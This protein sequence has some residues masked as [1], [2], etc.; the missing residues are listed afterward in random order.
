MP[1]RASV[2]R[3]GF[4]AVVSSDTAA[5]RM[6]RR[7]LLAA[8]AGI[9][10]FGATWLLGARAG[11]FGYFEGAIAF[12]ALT[13]ALFVALVL[14]ALAVVEGENDE[15][16]ETEAALRESEERFRGAFDNA[17]IG[18]ALVSP[19]GRWL[20]VNRSICE[21]LGYA[22]KELLATDFQ[23]VTHPDDLDADL[24][25]VEQTL[26][27]TIRDYR[28][29]KRYLH[30]GGDIVH[31]LLAVSLVR[32]RDGAPLYFVSQ[33]VDITERKRVDAALV[34]AK[35]AAEAATRTKS[36][37]LASMSHE[38]RTP[39]NAVIGFTG[40]LL[41]TELAAEQREFLETV[42]VSGETLLVLI[43]DILDFSKIES[44]KLELERQ[45]VDVRDCVEEALDLVAP[46]AGAKRLDLVA[47]IDGGAPQAVVGDV[48]RLR[49]ILVNLLSNAVKFTHEGEVVVTADARELGGGRHELH[50]AVRDTG[51]GI[52]AERID[53]LFHAFTQVDASVTRQYG[54]TG[55]GLAICRRLAELMGGTVWAESEV[56]RGS[57]F[58]FTI[59]CETAVVPPRPHGA[60]R[61]LDGKR[62]LVVDD[63]DASRSVLAEE[64]RASGLVPMTARSAAEALELVARG[65]S[66]DVVVSE[67]HMP[68][69]DGLGLVAWLR[70]AGV[71][72][73]A[74]LLGWPADREAL[75]EA[76]RRLDVAAIL[77]KPVKRSQ[78]RG[79]LADALAGEPRPDA[80]RA[81]APPRPAPP[82]ALRPKT[83]ER[84]SLRILVAED[85]AVNRKVALNML[86]RL[87][88]AAD[89]ATNGLE[90][91]EALERRPYDV[92]LMDV[93]MPQLDGLEATRRIR[94]ELPGGRL[95]HIIAMTANA[96]PGDR[97]ECLEAGMDD[98]LAKPVRPVDL[99]A[100]LERAA[101]TTSPA[102]VAAS[103]APAAVG[104]VD[105]EQLRQMGGDDARTA[106]REIIDIYLQDATHRIA[107][108]EQ[109][110]EAGE[111]DA[112]QRL[113]HGL[114]GSSATV[115]A[116]GVAELA[117]ALEQVEDPASAGSTAGLVRELRSRFES[118]RE[119]LLAH[120]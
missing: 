39:M 10:L 19:D 95:P 1:G 9:A 103:P 49:Q 108:I 100:A 52:P 89:V 3:R 60:L 29:E 61:R 63:G 87:G 80:A 116:W 117:A 71:A 53:S 36:A 43:N 91:I 31:A 76:A 65:E 45:P 56:G 79:A 74:L 5:G 93:Q 78:L 107:A 30:K 90:A 102:D 62:L 105:L 59:R 99:R 113:S 104:D 111:S 112:V 66:F 22:E 21:M 42:R 86:D 98:Y 64:A 94:A 119:V 55:L 70:S 47:R 41:D 82:P 7:V 26:D 115:G 38:I 40:L 75:G 51:I 44:E 73:P 20:K 110:V 2:I 50:F 27:G 25:L 83:S 101:A 37:F 34:D 48:T 28:M 77:T 24:G 23:S 120:M 35:E 69:V 11:L 14:A 12:A 88:Y 54:G 109:A 85:N 97:E 67:L 13:A 16:A 15:R 118:A 46:A 4:S 72:V 84:S 106:V 92:V 8:V 18:I 17:P 6:A 57:T 68:G 96:L 32:G 33:V 81:A 58:H 114:K